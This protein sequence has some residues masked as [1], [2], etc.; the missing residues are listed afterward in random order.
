M[1][2]AIITVTVAVWLLVTVIDG[3]RQVSK[4]LSLQGY[5]YETQWEFQLIAY[6]FTRFIVL[7]VILA[8]VL[9][10]EFKFLPKKA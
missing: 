5:G 7:L 10:V 3:Y 9:L 1:R 4:G 8:V 6:L 2:R